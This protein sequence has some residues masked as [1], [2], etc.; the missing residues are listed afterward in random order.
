[1]K[2]PLVIASALFPLGDPSKNGGVDENGDFITNGSDLSSTLDKLKTES[3]FLTVDVWDVGL[4]IITIFF[5]LG[6]LLMIMSII[7]KNGQWQKWAQGTM[8]VSFV[9]M[10]FIR[11]IPIVILSFKSKMDVHEAFDGLLIVLEQV[12][13]FMGITGLFLGLL[14]RLAYKLIEHPEYHRWSKNVIGIS[15]AMMF[16]S[17]F[18]PMIFRVF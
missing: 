7:F 9:A 5:I 8:L 11:G 6:V 12:T 15:A 2:L 10:I 3:S 14:F 17:I 13:I 18:G 16:F 1:M 4:K